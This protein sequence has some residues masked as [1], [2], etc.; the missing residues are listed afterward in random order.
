[1]TND[2]PTIDI[3]IFL[4]FK[5]RLLF[6]SILLFFFFKQVEDIDDGEGALI[7]EFECG[8]GKE[9][10]RALSYIESDHRV[11]VL[12]TNGVVQV[13]KYIHNNNNDDDDDNK[14]GKK[15]DSLTSSSPTMERVCSLTR[16][17]KTGS[18]ATCLAS[19]T[20][21]G[22]GTAPTGTGRVVASGTGAESLSTGGIANT[23]AL[24]LKKKKIRAQE[25]AEKVQNEEDGV[26]VSAGQR[27][28]DFMKNSK[29]SKKVRQ[30]ERKKEKRKKNNSMID[31]SD[32][33]KKRNEK[34][35]NDEEKK[36]AKKRQ[37]IEQHQPWKLK[38]GKDGAGG[39]GGG[40][41]GD[42]DME[43]KK[44]SKKD[45]KKESWKEEKKK[46]KAEKALEPK[47]KSFKQVI[48]L[49]KKST[50]QSGKRKRKHK[51]A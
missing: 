50:P 26:V 15:K 51:G 9:R 16:V 47:I 40:A 22:A 29:L 35:M 5:Y 34:N 13:W 17:A 41:G 21:E 28:S 3:F 43:K 38:D 48:K 7:G 19:C 8:M 25:R 23:D 33:T 2:G 12:F 20:S 6:V 1:L 42:D 11:I 39:A 30:A 45:A 31:S 27:L 32:G 24:Y 10:I 37:R 4:F 46:R 49:K 18:R 36:A 44:L 14:D